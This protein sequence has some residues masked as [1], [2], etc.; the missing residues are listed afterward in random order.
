MLSF[1]GEIINEAST[2][3]VVQIYKN[4]SQ[5]FYIDSYTSTGSI[6]DNISHTWLSYLKENDKVNLKITN[7]KMYSSTNQ[8]IT[9]KME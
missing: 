2:Y 1:S 5:D 3:T 7:G 9:F 8:R 6:Y 4:G